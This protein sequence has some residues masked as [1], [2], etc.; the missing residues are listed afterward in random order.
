MLC[1]DPNS[2][3]GVQAGYEHPCS[4]EHREN[5]IVGF[6]IRIQH[7][8][9][10]WSNMDPIPTESQSCSQISVLSGKNQGKTLLESGVPYFGIN[11]KLMKI[12]ILVA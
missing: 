3:N 11:K 4:K 2:T 9:V 1:H 6:A 10:E 7:W 5:L 8:A 12:R